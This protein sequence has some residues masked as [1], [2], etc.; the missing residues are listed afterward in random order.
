MM[1]KTLQKGLHRVGQK[2]FEICSPL[3]HVTFVA[4]SM[5]GYRHNP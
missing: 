2:G 3:Q 5:M 4:C 1:T